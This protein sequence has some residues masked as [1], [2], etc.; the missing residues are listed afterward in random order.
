CQSTKSFEKTIR[1]NKT[2]MKKLLFITA[3]AFATFLTSCSEDE[4]SDITEEID[5][6]SE[7]T[8][9]ANYEDIDLS[10]LSLWCVPERP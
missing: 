4:V 5:I 10:S 1:E 9:E 3:I 8:F 6:D 7:A 2:I